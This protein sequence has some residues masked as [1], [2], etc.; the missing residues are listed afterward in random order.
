MNMAFFY[1]GTLWVTDATVWHPLKVG[2]WGTLAEKTLKS[3]MAEEVVLVAPQLYP[4]S[5][6]TKKWPD[7]V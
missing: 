4:E 1:D 5:D 2:T 7:T 6:K 3:W